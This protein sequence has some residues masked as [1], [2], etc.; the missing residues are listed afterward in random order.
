M[1]RTLG[2][3]ARAEQS[4]VGAILTES[5]QLLPIQDNNLVFFFSPA[6]VLAPSRHYVNDMF[7]AAGE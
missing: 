2:C 4:R 3:P 7:S 1:L 6:T 5:Q